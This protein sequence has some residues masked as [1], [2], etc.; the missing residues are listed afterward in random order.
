M[1]D[2]M[3]KKLQEEMK[4]A[5]K[6]KDKLALN[7]IRGVLSAIQ[8][9]EMRKSKDALSDEEIISVIRSEIKKRV[10][11]L[12]YAEKD[13][14]TET[15]EE[16]KAEEAVLKNFLPEQMTEEELTAVV[17][18]YKAENPAINMGEVMK[19]L[20]ESYAGKYDGKLASSVVKSVLG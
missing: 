5:M 19:K 1:E 10:E 4:N 6:S 8:Y 7:T 17:Q 13:G 16:L 9:E 2:I 14:R 12:E 15:V 3:K 11:A 18:G 20:K